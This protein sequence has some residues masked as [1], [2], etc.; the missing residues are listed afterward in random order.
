MTTMKSTALLVIDMQICQARASVITKAQ[1]DGQGQTPYYLE[2]ISTV[3]EPNILRLLRQFRRNNAPIAFTRLVTREVDGS[4]L[5]PY[6]QQRNQAAL[7]QYGQA[8]IPHQH[9]PESNLVETMNPQDNELVILKSTSGSFAGTSLEEWLRTRNVSDIVL[10]GVFTNLC[11]DSTARAA[12]DLG[13]RA[14]VA[15]DACA[16]FT[17]EFHQNALLSLSLVYANIFSTDEILS[18]MATGEGLNQREGQ[19]LN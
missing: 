6:L 13:F 7:E 18:K 14:I 2:Q 8:L 10:T 11:V 3:A 4:D 19:R 16:A 1:P 15:T 5:P 17:P 9:A 12:F